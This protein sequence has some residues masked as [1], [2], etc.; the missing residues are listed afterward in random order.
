MQFLARLDNAHQSLLS[1]GNHRSATDDGMP[2]LSSDDPMGGTGFSAN[3]P[4]N[5]NA[6]GIFSLNMASLQCQ[7]GTV[8][9]CHK[10]LRCKITLLGQQIA[11]WWIEATIVYSLKSTGED[12]DRSFSK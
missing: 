11:D 1:G 2:L 9:R 4:Q 7:I 8:G 12:K 10:L 5:V 6:F 3:Q